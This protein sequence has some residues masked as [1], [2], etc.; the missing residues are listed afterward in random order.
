MAK[1]RSPRPGAD[2]VGPGKLLSPTFKAQV[3]AEIGKYDRRGYSQHQIVAAIAPLVK[4]TQ[5]R[6]C[7]LLKEVRQQYKAQ[8]VE[9]RAEKVAEMLQA[10][11]DV[12]AEAW[13]CYE[14]S[15]TDSE[16]LVRESVKPYEKKEPEKNGKGA[17]GHKG[18][19]AEASLVLLKE[20]YTTEGRLPANVYL[21]TVLDTLKAERE[22]LGLDAPKLV[23]LKADLTATGPSVWDVLAQVEETPALAIVTS[24][25]PIE[26]IIEE[27]GQ[28][29]EETS[30]GNQ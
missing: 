10:Y 22:L 8:I 3:L 9:D 27:A 30:D 5:P 20:I 25:D 6:I 15:K 26:R 4:L 18:E 11:R 2:P 7:T 12:R 17:T 24:N 16:R 23:D 21:Q 1:V 13:A 28:P 29:L 19:S 14:K